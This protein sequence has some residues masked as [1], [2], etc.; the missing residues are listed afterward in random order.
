ML[1]IFGR[2]YFLG[3]ILGG[4]IPA[5]HFQ[6]SIF[7]GAHFGGRILALY[8]WGH[9]FWDITLCFIDYFTFST[10]VTYH[11]LL[12]DIICLS[13]LII[14]IELFDTIFAT[15]NRTKN[16]VVKC[17]P[18]V[19]DCEKEEEERCAICLEAGSGTI[20]RLQCQHQFH[21]SASPVGLIRVIATL[22]V[23]LTWQPLL[24]K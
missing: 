14:I 4:R 18:I 16:Q 24:F 6:G 7:S 15:P 9:N 17:A 10:T 22:Y 12:D 11:K 5:P 19:L 3:L 2:A 20:I 1:P 8:S 21:E 13:G 23:V